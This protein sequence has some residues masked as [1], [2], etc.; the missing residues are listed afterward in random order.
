MAIA[1]PRD[2]AGS[3]WPCHYWHKCIEPHITQP[4]KAIGVNSSVECFDWFT[5]WRIKMQRNMHSFLSCSYVYQ[6]FQESL[7]FLTKITAPFCC[8][9]RS[10]ECIHSLKEIKGTNSSLGSSRPLQPQPPKI[11]YEWHSY[12]SALYTSAVPTGC[13]MLQ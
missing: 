3:S 12:F 11:W 9:A 8:T 5:Q 2:K 7:A 10:H 13:N 4:V 1:M 6:L